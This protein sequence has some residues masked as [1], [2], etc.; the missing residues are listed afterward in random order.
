MNRYFR[1]VA[2][3]FDGTLTD[4]GVPSEAALAAIDQARNE[5]LCIVLATGRILAELRDVFPAVDRYFDA[6][7]AENGAT[8]SIDGSDRILSAPVE[9]ELDEAL[10]ARSVPF[11]RGQVLLATH[12]SCEKEIGEEVHRLG[13]DCQ[14]VHNRGELMVLPPGITKG[15][16][17]SKVLGSLGIS[18]HNAN[19]IGDAE[20]D[21][22][23]L[24]ACELG[25]AVRNA[26][27]GLKRHADLVLDQPDGEGVAALLRGILQEDEIAVRSDRWRIE[28]GQF[29]TG[30]P[31]AI[32]ASRI[33]LLITGRSKSGKSFAAGA[34]A[35]RLVELGYSVCLIDP[36]GDYTSLGRLHGVECL[37][38]AGQAPDGEEIRRLL[39][40]RFGSVIV[41]LSLVERDNQAAFTQALLRELSNDRRSTGLPHWIVVDEA[42]HAL[43]LPGELT[44]ILEGGQK[45]WCLVTYQPQVFEDQLCTAMDYVLALPE[46]RRLTG[47]DPLSELERICRL[48]VAASLLDA[49]SGEGLLIDL[50]RRDLFR[51][52]LASRRTAHVRHWHKYVQG[53]LPPWL[54][55]NFSGRDGSGS[56]SAANVQEFCDVV[57][58]SAPDVVAFHG[59]RSDFSRWISE[60]LQEEALAGTVRSIEQQYIASDHGAV[61]VAALRDGVVRAVMQ[62][63]G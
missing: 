35:E 22:S 15:S 1:A 62:H 21:H 39:S 18:Y 44:E 12:V 7:V 58:E 40:H 51:L 53:R 57:G 3:D 23:L 19:G 46:G 16:G 43:G 42:H 10:I 6:V 31:A 4:G 14:L 5:C 45:G 48:P 56:S 36:E 33:N 13:L 34:I 41:D 52:Q 47:P 8:A 54:R 61:A 63:Y 38:K 28:L 49:K 11:R 60:A 30:G 25:V 37:C 20:N 17:L 50:T 55:F 59:E 2:V 24:N 29:V 27:E 9:R 32:P 26:V